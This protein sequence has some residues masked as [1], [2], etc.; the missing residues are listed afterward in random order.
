MKDA[1]AGSG[2]ATPREGRIHDRGSALVLAVFVLV[3]LTAMGTA[4]LFLSQNEAKMGQASLRVKSAFYLAEAA[5][6]DGRTTLFATNGLDPFDDDLEDAAGGDPGDTIDFDPEA[7]RASYD[8]DGNVTGLTGFGNDVPLRALT[9]LGVA[10]QPGWYAAF[11]TNDPVDGPTSKVDTNERVMVTGVGAGRDQSFELVQAIL[12][13][14]QFLPPVPAAALTLLGPKPHF[15]NGD[16]AAQEHTGNDCGLPGGAFAPIVGTIGDGATDAVQDNM[17]RPDKFSSGPLPFEGESTVGNLIDPA[18]PIVD[19]AGHGTIEPA[20]LECLAL[21]EMVDF[22]AIAADYYC[23]ADIES[24][25]F[26]ATSPDTVVFIDGDVAGTPAGDYSGILVVTGEL[27]YNGATGWDG[28]ILNIGEGRLLRS[29]GGSRKPSGGVVVAS[30]DPTPNGPAPDRDDWCTT[31]PDG[32]EP[33][34]Y[35]TSGGGNSTVEWCSTTIDLA[36]TVRSYRVTE[37]LQ[38]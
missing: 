37:F 33:A 27:V 26:P 21:K 17:Q 3:L 13:P 22:L 36:N 31:P 29:G 15:D 34:Y 35:D 14:F 9:P 4:L 30:I 25:T 11:L 7:I 32:F 10:G 19:G 23:N 18:D 12:E 20:W 28:I 1:H 8:A 6:E 24:C 2:D 38:R 5:I 16:S